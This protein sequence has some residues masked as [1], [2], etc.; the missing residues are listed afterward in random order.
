MKRL[1]LAVVLLST[2][3]FASAANWSANGFRVFQQ[4][5]GTVNEIGLKQDGFGSETLCEAWIIEQQVLTAPTIT[6]PSGQN[7]RTAV[8]ARCDLVRVAI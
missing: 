5:N 1:T 2:S 4:A 3:G 6:T 7:L 8:Y